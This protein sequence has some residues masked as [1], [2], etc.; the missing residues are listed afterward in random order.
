MISYNLCNKGKNQKANLKNDIYKK[1][2]NKMKVVNITDVLLS[3]F[4]K[5]VN[6]TQKLLL[7]TK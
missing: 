2:I 6:I 7:V 4:K 1:N 5:V 3:G